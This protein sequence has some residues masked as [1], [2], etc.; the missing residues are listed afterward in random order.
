MSVV[1]G[2][3]VPHP[4]LILPEVG[5]G[6]EKCIEKTS[7]AYE[8]AAQFVADLAPETIVLSS[9][10]SIMYADYL[11]ISPGNHAEGDMGRF[12]AG[13]VKIARDYDEEMAIRIAD[14]CKEE[15]LPAGFLGERDPSLDH[16]TLIPLYFILKKYQNFR[17]IRLG[18]SGISLPMHYRIGMQIQKAAEELGRRVVYVASGDL[19]HK[20]KEDGPYGLS[21]EGPEYDRRIM[22]DMGNAD[23]EN[24]LRYDGVFLDKAAE[25]GHRSFVLLAG[26]LDGLSV[27]AKKLSHEDITGVGYGICT[28]EVTGKDPARHF[29]ASYEQKEKA[30]IQKEAEDSDPYVALARKTIEMY[31]RTGIVPDSR[32][33]DLN[34]PEKMQKDRAGTFVSIH[35]DGELRG[36]IGT[37]LPVRKN[38]AQEIID[39]AVSACSR[40]PRFSRV[41]REE[42]PYLEI[43]V[44]VLSKPEDISSQAELDPKKY[45]VIVTKGTRRGLLLPDLPGVDTPEQQIRIAKRKAGIGESEAVHLSRFTVTRHS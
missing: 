35:E 23:F 26:A 40:D 22:E 19:S 7:R 24:L 2:I 37:I 3:M 42:L 18:I 5:R 13:K 43:S 38:I 33:K 6:E 31:I 45:G 17:L 27:R 39:N 1:G 25:C 34:L 30:K 21:K 32:D 29:L 41:R 11:H 36:C 20:L 8:A 12:R 16:G 14:L 15:D 44:D 10:H 9:P 28:F 4:P